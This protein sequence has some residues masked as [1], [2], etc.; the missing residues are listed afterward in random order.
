VH[1]R[2]LGRDFHLLWAA[3]GLSNIGDGLRVTA[4]PLLATAATDDP[5]LIAGVAV[6]ELIPWLVFIL[7]G[8]AWADRFDRRRLRMWLDTARAIVMAVLVVVI[9]F[10]RASIVVIYVIAAL[11]AS[12]EA[13][14]DSSSMALVP[15]TV[16]E[17]DLER[18]VGR[19]SSTEL[20]T[21]G[22][23]GPPI[24]G[25]LFGFAVVAPFAI[26]A[27][28][29]VAAA[30]VVAAM[31]GTY[32]PASTEPR[33]RSLRAEIGE[34][35][36]WLWGH[37]RLRRLALVSTALGTADFIGTAVFV[38]F[39]RDVL[40]LSAGGYGLLLVPVALGGIAGSLLA[41]RLTS[42]PLR[43]VLTVAILVSGVATWAAS[44]SSEPV[45]VG[46]LTGVSAAAVLVWNVL[47]IALRQR[48]IPDRLL[49]RVG[50]SYRFLVYLGMPLGALAGGFLAD[51]FGVRTALAVNGIALVVI[52]TTIPLALRDGAPRGVNARA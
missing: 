33:H 2:R 36:R 18:A 35:F 50:A 39:A 13:V 24:G 42:I 4:L 15:A 40:G 14:V 6:A 46:V 45:I 47:T 41:G 7:P 43:P 9:A 32:A 21:N 10:D 37:R 17:R 20:A 31:S 30:V 28:T 48:I 34:G 27:L 3:T 19:L 44:T 8:G 38:L 52:A 29:F 12:G 23:I 25:L 11:L 1:D 26:D 16:H 5:R 49:G 22:L 51:A